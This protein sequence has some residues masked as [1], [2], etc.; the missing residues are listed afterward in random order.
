MTESSSPLGGSTSKEQIKQVSEGHLPNGLVIKICPS[1][2]E[3]VGSIL[4]GEQRYLW[5]DQG[6]AFFVLFLKSFCRVFCRYICI[7]EFLKI[8]KVDNFVD[9]FTK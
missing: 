3:A 2:A 5:Y 4:F 1:S 8:Y 6:F 9:K 7:K